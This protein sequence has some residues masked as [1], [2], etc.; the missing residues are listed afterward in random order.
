MEK[1][2]REYKDSVRKL[3]AAK[4]KPIEYSSMISDTEFAITCMETGAIPG[5]RWSV[6]RCH[7]GEIPMDPLVLSRIVQNREPVNS[8]PDWVVLFLEKLMHTLTEKEKDAYELVR[9]RGYSFAQ[10]GRLMQCSKSTVQIHIR[11]AERKIQKAVRKETAG[12]TE[13]AL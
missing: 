3:R 13:A 5:T 10:A 1:L 8:A 4:V 11:R 12:R 6:P 7:A 9:G 2:I